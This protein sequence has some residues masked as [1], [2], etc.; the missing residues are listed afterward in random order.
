MCKSL[1]GSAGQLLFSFEDRIQSQQPN[2][3]LSQPLPQDERSRRVMILLAIASVL[4]TFPVWLATYPPMVDLPQHM[5]QVAI[6]RNLRDPAFRFAGLFEV[7]WFTPYLLGY[8]AVY[9]LTPV[10][11]IVAASKVVISVALAG[12]PMATGLLMK[13]VGGDSYWALLTIPTMYGFTYEWGFLNFLIAV[14]V[15]LFFLLLVIRTTRKPILRSCILLG[16]FAVLLFFCHALICIFLGFIA[17]VYMLVEIGNVKKA[18]LTTMP[19]A[20]VVPIAVAWYLRT[21]SHPATQ[22]A[23]LWDL[24]WLHSAGS[25]SLGGRLTGFFPRLLGLEGDVICFAVG[26]VLFALSLLG[27]A[28]PTRRMVLWMPFVTCLCVLLFCPT[29]AFGTDF[30]YQRFVV[31][32]LPFFLLGAS[33]AGGVR[34]AWRAVVVFVI[35]GWMALLAAR[36]LRYDTDARGFTN[37]LSGME[38]NQRVLSLM[39]V[40]LTESIPAPVFLHYPAWYS[41]TKKGIVDVSFALCY[42]ELVVYEPS[43]LPRAQLGF[44]LSPETFEWAKLNGSDY[45]YF[46]VRAPAN[47]GFQL[48]RGAPCGVSLAARSQDW[49]LY[50]KDPHC[51]PATTF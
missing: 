17:C 14:P 6:L 50:E 7:N 4:A 51:S 11:G 21:K 12:L 27:G 36:T 8:M 26:T 49:W 9:V 1:V 40:P 30:I 2:A 24:G 47:L 15:G 32:A 20:S 3:E 28:R 37:I 31:F 10:V 29:S 43:K 34:P 46:V 33:R 16:L 5:A 19:M 35:I 39:F 23:I 41:A 44:E 45:R 25:D 13:E 38:P 18:I 48:F 22:D 42:P